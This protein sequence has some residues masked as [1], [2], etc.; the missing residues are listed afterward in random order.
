MEDEGEFFWEINVLKSD[1]FTFFFS[2]LRIY[3]L[4]VRNP[5]KW[6]MVSWLFPFPSSFNCNWFLLEPCALEKEC[7]H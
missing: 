1:T 4:D 2:F 3:F 7:L 6:E 5:V